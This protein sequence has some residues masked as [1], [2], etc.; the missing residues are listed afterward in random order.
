MATEIASMPGIDFAKTD[1]AIALFR[2]F[3]YDRRL[4]LE[5]VSDPIE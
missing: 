2:G 1:F 3:E 4:I 5:T